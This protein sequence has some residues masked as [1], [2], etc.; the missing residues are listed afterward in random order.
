MKDKRRKEEVHVDQK[1]EDQYPHFSHYESPQQPNL[2]RNLPTI[3]GRKATQQAK[4]HPGPLLQGR[5]PTRLRGITVNSIP[6]LHTQDKYQN[7]SALRVSESRKLNVCMCRM[8]KCG[9]LFGMCAK[10]QSDIYMYLVPFAPL[11]ELVPSQS[12]YTCPC[13]CTMEKGFHHGGMGCESIPTS[14]RCR[15]T[16]MYQIIS[17]GC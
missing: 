15:R 12:D 2:P 14:G 6:H 13:T 7:A 11:G 5:H 17:S 1:K 16:H 10:S 8:T 9:Y 3:V 4:K